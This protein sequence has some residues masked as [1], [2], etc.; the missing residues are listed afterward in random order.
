MTTL[1][2]FLAGAPLDYL[3]FGGRDAVAFYRT[4]PLGHLSV[5]YKGERKRIEWIASRE[6]AERFFHSATE[7]H[8]P[9]A[10]ELAKAVL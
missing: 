5:G 9:L 3:S 1:E 4:R 2:Q 8:R 6:E 10:A 7:E